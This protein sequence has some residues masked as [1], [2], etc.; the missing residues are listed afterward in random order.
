MPLN[1]LRGQW[2]CQRRRHLRPIYLTLV[3]I[4]SRPCFGQ[5][6]DQ[7]GQCTICF[8]TLISSLLAADVSLH[9]N[10]MQCLPASREKLLLET[11]TS[12]R[13]TSPYGDNGKGAADLTSLA[14]PVSLISIPCHIAMT[15][16]LL[17]RS[18]ER[19]PRRSTKISRSAT[20]FW[21]VHFI[22]M[23][24]WPSQPTSTFGTAMRSYISCQQAFPLL[25]VCLKGS[26]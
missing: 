24:E 7:A 10:R 17:S 19:R 1:G 23:H 5:K 13:S 2:S 11:F 21:T 9:L 20:V 18:L 8:T 4:H 6:C 15:T 12:R 14:G 25:S 16:V 26:G 3:S 22:Q